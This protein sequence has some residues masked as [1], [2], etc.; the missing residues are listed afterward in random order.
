MFNTDD[1]FAT[2]QHRAGVAHSAGSSSTKVSVEPESDKEEDVLASD[3]IPIQLASPVSPIR[4][5]VP[6]IR[7]QRSVTFRLPARPTEDWNISW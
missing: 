5:E 3:A 6:Q 1:V 2:P 7:E 4:P